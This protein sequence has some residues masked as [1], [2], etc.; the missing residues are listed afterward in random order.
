MIE[1]TIWK[2]SEAI[3]WLVIEPEV[4][5]QTITIVKKKNGKGSIKAIYSEM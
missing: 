1:T 4:S 3:I 2:T 5:H